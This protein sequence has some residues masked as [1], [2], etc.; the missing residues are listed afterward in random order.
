METSLHKQLKSIYG[1][2]RAEFEVPVGPYRVDVVD[3]GRLIEI[4]HGSLTAIRDKV[5]QLLDDG[6]R[7]T[8]VKPIVARKRL[9]KRAEKRGEVVDR[10]LSPKRGRLLDLFDEL[11]HFTRTFPHRRLVLDVPLVEIEELRYPGH[12][13]RR[14][15]REN[16]HVVE[17]QRLIEVLETRRFRTGRDLARLIESPLPDPFHT[18]HLAESLHVP[19]WIAQR[20]AYC[21]RHAETI[22]QVDKHGN[23]ALYRFVGRRAANKPAA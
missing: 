11:V 10:R 4:Q 7:V 12:G 17:D 5:R 21:L 2:R 6:H 9:V 19:R 18:G 20:I 8:V 15:W 13:R 22:R 16:D 1:G 23:A 3:R 14:R